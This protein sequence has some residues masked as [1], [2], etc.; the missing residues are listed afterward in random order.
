MAVEFR[1]KQSIQLAKR[2][3]IRRMIVARH[4]VIFPVAHFRGV[5]LPL[6]FEFYI[7]DFVDEKIRHARIRNVG[8]LQ[9][10]SESDA[11]IVAA[12]KVKRDLPPVREIKSARLLLH[13]AP[14]GADV[15]LLSER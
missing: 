5:A 4:A 10:N 7:G 1:G 11:F 2:S 9:L 6:T 14:V 13:I 12:S 3:L 8:I 15:D